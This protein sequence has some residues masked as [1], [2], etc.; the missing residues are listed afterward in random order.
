MATKNSRDVKL[1]L[2]VDT[3][4]DDD[5]KKLQ[6]S[7][8]SLAKEGGDAAPEFQRLADEVAR[9]GQQAQAVEAFRQLSVETDQLAAKQIEAAAAT[10]KLEAALRESQAAANEAGAAQRKIE[11]DV[12]AA[13]AALTLTGGELTKLN[14]EYRGS[15]KSS[16]AYTTELARLIDRKSQEKISLDQAN[17][18]MRESRRAASEAQAAEADLEK[19]Y[20]RSKTALQGIEGAQRQNAAAVGAAATAAR[21]L[22]ISTDNVVATQ[23]QLLQSL[24]SVGTQAD[25]TATNV[26][27]L[28]AQNARV[29]EANREMIESDRLLAIEQATLADVY[30]S[31]IHI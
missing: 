23:A 24:N 1:T 3:L 12:L 5:I 16:E 15:A 31:L 9:I 29:A 6:T 26:R 2:S 27:E 19:T 7:I 4:G 22:G 20:V 21:E 28:A 30:L 25:R 18:A 14:A 13:R 11:R 17:A 8:A 10:A